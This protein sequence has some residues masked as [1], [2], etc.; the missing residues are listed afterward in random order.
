MNK[1]VSYSKLRANLAALLDEASETLE[2]IIVERRGKPR[3]A[4]IDAAELSS[5][6]ETLHLLRSPANAKALFQSLEQAR[7]GKAVAMTLDELKEKAGA[8]V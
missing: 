6:M 2:P 3:V 1:T 5:I 8:K 4:F 7:S